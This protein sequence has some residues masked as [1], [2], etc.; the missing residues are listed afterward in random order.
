VTDSQ[1]KL[2]KMIKQRVNHQHKEEIIPNI[3]NIPINIQPNTVTFNTKNSPQLYQ[4]ELK[5][6]KKHGYG[7]LISEEG[8]IIYEGLWKNDQY[9]GEGILLNHNPQD[10]LKGTFS[11]IEKNSIIPSRQVGDW[12][13]YSGS[14]FE[15]KWEGF[16]QLFAANGDKYVGQFKNDKANGKGDF[17]SQDG[18]VWQGEWQDNFLV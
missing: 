6:G 3:P 12:I 11:T 4:G 2:L 9:H 15:G 5:S 16:G 10:P 14:F 1:E 18:R 8:M 13:K 17:I 7:T